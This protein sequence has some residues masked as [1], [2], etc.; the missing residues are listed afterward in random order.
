[1]EY[2]LDINDFNKEEEILDAVKTI[3]KI[4]RSN[5]FKDYVDGEYQVKL[6][7]MILIIQGCNG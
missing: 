1:M 6:K 3:L 4:H 5:I 7:N 2:R